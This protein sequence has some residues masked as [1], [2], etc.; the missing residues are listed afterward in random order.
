[1]TKKKIAFISVARSD[2]GRLYPTMEVINNSPDF[3]L[4]LLVSGNHSSEKFGKSL[5]E[6]KSSGLD[7]T[8][9]IGLSSESMVQV[10]SQIQIALDKF[11]CKSPP[12]LFVI[13]GD[14]YEMMAAAQ[15]AFF[16]GIPIIHIGGGYQT[17]GAIDDQI[18]H[19]ITLLSTYHF[20]ASEN[21]RRR[22][23]ELIGKEENVFLSGAP[24]LEILKKLDLMTKDEFYESCS[25]QRN[26][27]FI[28]I[29]IH[30]ET[31]KSRDKNAEYLQSFEEFLTELEEQVL[32]TAPCADP[33][34]NLIFEMIE[35]L[36][37]NC[38]DL[39]YIE[40]LGMKRYAA[41][42]KYAEMMIGNSSSGIIESATMGIPVLN[43]G[44][45]QGG[46][47]CNEN[48]LHSSFE[49][50]ELLKSYEMLK[51]PAFKKISSEKSNIYGDGEFSSKFIKF[52][53]YLYS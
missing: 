24:D 11:F 37:K 34:A 8:Y 36:Q 10:S 27:S 15:A 26:R 31:M 5:D 38:S 13:L 12:D 25:L 18:R 51:E 3:D 46:R 52:I 33:G 29:T 42:M 30:P 17:S 22:V 32:I 41:A 9:E 28:L 48:V 21:C 44:D 40:S 49:K 45:R 35:R 16:N 43:I 1:M 6:I 47:E 23:I 20:T 39:L 50:A 19:A 53:T 2:Y 4:Q 7:I 14:R